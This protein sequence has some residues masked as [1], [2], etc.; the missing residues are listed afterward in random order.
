[1]Q[2]LSRVRQIL[3]HTLAYALKDQANA[4][5]QTLFFECVSSCKFPFTYFLW[6]ILLLQYFLRMFLF[7][8]SSTFDKIFLKSS[9]YML[10]PEHL[11]PGPGWKSN[12]NFYFLSQFQYLKKV[13]EGSYAACKTFLR[14][15]KEK[16]ILFQQNFLKHS[17]R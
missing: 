4:Y 8:Q 16:V 13:Y 14:N 6:K 5:V 10:N 1:M 15:H 3:A 9:A 11:Y 12:G 2:L 17:S 7:Y